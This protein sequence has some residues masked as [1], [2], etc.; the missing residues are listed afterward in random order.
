MDEQQKIRAALAKLTAILAGIARTADEK[1]LERCPY[2]TV[3]LCCTYSGGCQNQRRDSADMMCGG[4]E[5]VQWTPDRQ[6]LK[7][8]TLTGM[9]HG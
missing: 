9:R 8:H 1:N 4:D 5:F 3:A 7:P 6:R 2:K